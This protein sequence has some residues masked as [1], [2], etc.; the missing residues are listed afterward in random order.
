MYKKDY[1]MRLMEQLTAVIAQVAKLGNDDEYQEALDTT[2][3]S[4]R[5][6]TGLGTDAWLSMEPDD[7]LAN[8]SMRDDLGGMET[9]VFMV[10]MFYEEGKIQ[11]LQGY[12]DAADYHVL[13]ALQLHLAIL[14]TQPNIFMPDMIPSVPELEVRLQNANVVVPSETSQAL[15]TYYEFIEKYDTVEDV[16][17]MWVESEPGNSEA[18]EAG[19]TF[20]ER[21]LLKSNEELEEGGLP[22]DEVEAGLEELLQL[23]DS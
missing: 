12:A 16:L 7:I 23:S 8:L 18:V 2:D 10:G 4:L 1:F 19:I 20:Y 14:N 22:R 17:F 3:S 15:M 11:A 6:L 21:L 9:A 5:Q 13:K